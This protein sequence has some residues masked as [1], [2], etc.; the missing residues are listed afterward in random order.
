[1]ELDGNSA[2]EF[3][4]GALV[5]GDSSFSMAGGTVSNNSS[6]NGGDFYVQEASITLSDG[7]EVADN[8]ALNRGAGLSL[9]LQ[10]T[11]VLT[12][13]LVEDNDAEFQDG[14]GLYVSGSSAEIIN[15]D[16]SLCHAQRGGAVAL[17]FG[18]YLAVEGGVFEFNNANYGGA[19]HASDSEVELSDGVDILNN[20]VAYYGGAIRLIEDSEFSMAGGSIT[21][22]SAQW[23]GGLD[24]DDSTAELMSVTL[25]R[26]H[27]TYRG[28]GAYLQGSTLVSMASNWG[29][30][31]SD[32]N[33]P[34]DIVIGTGSSQHTYTQIGANSTFTCSGT[35]CN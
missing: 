17:A 32:D 18:S 16:I 9:A 8:T 29:A 31:G 6:P 19:I 15:T 11:A 4:G 21:D 27:A 13:G 35:T 22:N 33:D 26:N 25:E 30:V 1:M 7:F 14:G 23:G 34:D 2:T 24:V 3:G 28:G 20:S 10:S 12:D 5:F